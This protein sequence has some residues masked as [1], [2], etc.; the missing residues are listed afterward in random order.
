MLNNYLAKKVAYGWN[1]YKLYIKKSQRGKKKQE[2]KAKQANHFEQ[3]C[4]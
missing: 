4:G 3:C 2:Q 1:K